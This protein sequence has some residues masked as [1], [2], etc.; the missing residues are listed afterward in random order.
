MLYDNG[1]PRDFVYIAVNDAFERL[2]G[3][4]NV[5]GKKVS[6]VIPGIQESNRELFEIYGR[7]AS[8]GRP[9]RFETYVAPLGTWFSIAV[10]SPG[11]EHFIAVFDNITERKRAEEEREK[12]E[13][14]LRQAQKMESV[15]R[16]AGGVA[17]DFN[18][19]L[20]V[21]LAYADMAMRKT[22]PA[23]PL[24]RELEEIHQA[25]RR[26]ADLTSRL[27]AFARKQIISPQVLGLNETLAGMLTMLRR[28][29]GEDV[30]LVWRPGADLWKVNI[31]PSQIDQLL[32]N[33]VVN[34]RDAIA[35]TGTI[36]L[37]TENATLD[38]SYCAG[39]VGFAPGEYVLLAVSDTGTGMSKEVLQNVFEPFFTTKDVGKG[40]GLGLA[41]VYGIVKQ[42]NG[43]INAYS[44]LDHGTI[45]KIYLPRFQAETVEAPAQAA[46][47]PPRRG[48][49][50]VLIVEDEASIL[51]LSERM[52]RELGYEVLAADSA[53][54]ALRLA[55]E[56][57]GEIHLL[58]TD[59][60]MP[61]MNGRDLADRLASIKPGL[62]YLFMSGYTANVIA[63]RGILDE[64]VSF[65]QKPFSMTT[66]AQKIREALEG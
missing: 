32:A 26:S 66:L 46:T 14:Q 59:V 53:A 44:E 8:T 12:L 7:V 65:L 10:Y 56:H 22:D 17:H 51:K 45:F 27:L 47:A 15:G 36:T 41:T 30:D 54:E 40:T 49:E 21:I 2:T 1:S 63:H 50:T 62:K 13:S 4:K 18:N 3:L 34:A 37:E 6:E 20:T 33:L 52:L 29:I 55:E 28:L 60:V 24:H 23:L 61:E 5:V 25:A 48:T 64:G 38:E 35:D 19:Q 11:K 31:D 58:M 43:F 42:N 9:E 57:A 16:L 39:H